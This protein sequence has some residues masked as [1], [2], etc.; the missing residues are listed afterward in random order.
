MLTCTQ[1]RSGYG[2]DD[3][4]AS[5]DG[6]EGDQP[7]TKKAKLAKAALAKAK[8]KAKA[9]Q[10]KKK[11]DASASDDDDEDEYNALPIKN[12][13]RITDL[14]DPTARP[15]IGSLE[16]CAE[17]HKEFTMVSRDG[18]FLCLPSQP[19]LDALYC[20]C[21]PRPG[22]AMPRMCQSS[23]HRSVQEGGSSK[24]KSSYRE[25]ESREL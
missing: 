12:S 1:R 19:F 22:M 20:G 8:A 10:K 11:G 25:E 5:D 9:K 17:C 2:S 16:E 6:D 18:F 24:T 23:R 4:D 14:D 21:R 3:L 13:R 7:K 15:P